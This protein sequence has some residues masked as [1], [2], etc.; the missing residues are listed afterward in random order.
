MQ[1]PAKEPESALVHLEKQLRLIE[2]LEESL[3]NGLNNIDAELSRSQRPRRD[4]PKHA[5]APTFKACA[6][7]Y[8]CCA[9][10]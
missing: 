2:D 8:S 7:T 6:T 10:P 4:T 5:F 1:A 9:Q 3:L